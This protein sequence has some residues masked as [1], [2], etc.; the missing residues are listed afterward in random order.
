MKRM[1][2]KLL[3]GVNIVLGALL[4]LLG[5]VYANAQR[6][7]VKYGVPSADIA[8]KGKV[9]DERCRPVKDV[10]VIVRQ[11]VRNQ[12]DTLLTNKRGRFS[13]EPLRSWP[14]D[15]VDLLVVDPSGKYATDSVQAPVRYKKNGNGFYRGTGKAKAKIRLKS[16]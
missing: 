14:V 12:Q 10:Q 8:V 11:K 13:T 15:S 7:M 3:V 1:K 4:S 2:N 6:V 16:K 9:T 5:I